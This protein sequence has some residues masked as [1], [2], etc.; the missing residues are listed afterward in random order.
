MADGTATLAGRGDLAAIGRDYRPHVLLVEDEPGIAD[1]LTRGLRA[2]GYAVTHAV[3]GSLGHRLAEKGRFSLVILD[4][5]IPGEMG[6]L[7]LE[8]LQR[9]S[10]GLP[11]VVMSASEQGRRHVAQIVSA[12]IRFIGKPFAMADL[13]ALVG[14]LLSD[15]HPRADRGDNGDADDSD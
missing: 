15:D 7:V 12:P 4:W 14:D 5:M 6:G 2:K 3:N 9:S 11:I 1:F 8:A 13:L 10:P